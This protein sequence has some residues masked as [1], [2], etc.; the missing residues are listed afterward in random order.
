MSAGPA[1]ADLYA[2]LA[3]LSRSLRESLRELGLDARLTHLAG[4]DMPDARL[5]LDHVVQMTEE[6][7]HRT[8]DLVDDGRAVAD[9]LADVRAHLARLHAQSMV[10]GLPEAGVAL[11]DAE[12]RLRATLTALAQAQ[13]YQDLS[14]QMIRR[15]IDLLRRVESALAELLG[16]EGAVQSAPPLPINPAQ[17]GLPGPA[18]P[19][20]SGTADQ[21]DADRL[22]ASLGF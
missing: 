19:G 14:G 11:H 3:R 17:A 6:A 15:V 10:H 5:R 7:A 20:T 18:L 12:S 9:G 13:E 4:N 2:G 22:L 21:G 16:E 1:Q 8:L